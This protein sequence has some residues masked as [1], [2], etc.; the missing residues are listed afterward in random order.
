MFNF[1]SQVLIDGRDSPYITHRFCHVSISDA[2]NSYF[3]A[4]TESVTFLGNHSENTKYI[5]IWHLPYYFFI[6]VSSR[7]LYAIPGLDYVAHEDI[8]PYKTNE[9]NPLQVIIPS[10]LSEKENHLSQ[11]RRHPL[12]ITCIDHLSLL[13][14]H[15]LFDKFLMFSEGREPP[16]QAQDTLR[17]WQEKVKAFVF[18]YILT[19]SA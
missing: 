15:E 11:Q 5:Y 3:R 4:Q 2:K 19:S 10:K 16:F 18:F 8:L 1:A 13:P 7:N 17:A 12:C 6:P 14:Q 9:T